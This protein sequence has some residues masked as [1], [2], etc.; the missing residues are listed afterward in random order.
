MKHVF[1]LFSV[2][3]L[4]IGVLM[5]DNIGRDYYDHVVQLYNQGDYDNAKHGFQ[6]CIDKFNADVSVQNCN[7][8]IRLCNKHIAARQA[9]V[10]EKKKAAERA[11]AAERKALE[12]QTKKRIEDRLVYISTDAFIF[13]RQYSTMHSAIKGYLSNAGFNFTDDPE[14]AYW[15]VYVTA[16]AYEYGQNDLPMTSGVGKLYNSAV[17]ASIKIV[18]NISDRN[19]YENEIS[20][21]YDRNYRDKDSSYYKAA[22]KVYTRINSKLGE[23][24]ENNLK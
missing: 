13:D 24:I 7:E 16:C 12:E 14:K 9:A 11:A 4:S 19:I 10:L 2:L 20:G 23:L 21:E 15:S 3:V 1:A 18:D 22:M 6:F 8:Y 5:A 17:G